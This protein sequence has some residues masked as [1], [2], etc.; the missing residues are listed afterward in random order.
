MILRATLALCAL[1]ACAALS[2]LTRPARAV[3]DLAAALEEATAS[4][5][6]TVVHFGRADRPLC[7]RMQAETLASP[8]ALSAVSDR[9][10]EIAIDSRAH[11]DAFEQLTG[12]KGSLAT[13]VVDAK[14]ELVGRLPGFA[15]TRAYLRFLDTVERHAA[16]L[17]SA[18]ARARS[19]P[20]DLRARGELADALL[21]V[22]L[23][24]EAGSTLREA[25]ANTTERDDAPLVA[26]LHER[27]AR[28]CVLRGDPVEARS[29]LDE[30][31][32]LDPA[33]RAH[34]LDRAVLSEALV[35]SIERRE[36][37]ARRLLEDS[38]SRAPICAEEDARLLALGRALHETGDD[39]GALDRLER[40]A[41]EHS[42]SPLL[43][44]AE[45]LIAHIHGSTP[46]HPR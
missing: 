36:S 16:Q 11:A 28:L 5:K 1:C 6:L 24:R 31:R 2:M 14:G 37:E 46:S 33:D 4:G 22:G 9:F 19:Q 26:S 18:R 10:V 20:G 15:E 29:H 17:A 30:Y 32:R 3:G 35:L 41:R 34:R 8:A 13:C 25:T 23:E 40:L 27:L 42:D 39:A 12:E 45:G 7:A 44:R 38:Q 43:F 21:E